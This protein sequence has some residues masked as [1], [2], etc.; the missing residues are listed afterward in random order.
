MLTIF[1]DGK[2]EGEVV[3]IRESRFVIGRVDGDLR[4]PIDTR[5]S[6]KHAEITCQEVA[7]AY[8]WVVTDL[9]STNGTFIRIGRTILSDKSEFL[10]GGGR[11]VYEGLQVDASL[12][13]ELSVRTGSNQTVGWGGAPSAVKPPTL[14]EIVGNEIAG[15]TILS[16][17]EYWI[18]ADAGCE[19]RRA[20]D[21]YCDERHARLFRDAKGVWQIENNRSLNGLW[22]RMPQAAVEPQ[23]QFQLGEQRFRIQIL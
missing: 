11:Y 12:T 6:S 16:K 1:D 7:G 3:R 10:V 19:I 22:L 15:R 5:I 18:G 17:S 20:D 21:P 23:L 4:I 2:S 13:S 9:Q 8:R 14:T